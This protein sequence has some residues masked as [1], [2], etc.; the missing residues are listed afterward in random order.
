MLPQ[1]PKQIHNLKTEGGISFHAIILSMLYPLGTVMERERQFIYLMTR[2]LSRVDFAKQCIFTLL[3][4]L[5][6]SNQV[7]REALLQFVVSDLANT[8]IQ[9]WMS[10]F[11]T[12]DLCS[13][14]QKNGQSSQ[15]TSWSYEVLWSSTVN[16]QPYQKDWL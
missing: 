3:E 1:K 13:Q 2:K 12:E 4:N 16:G 9:S 6:F 5:K 10:T 11:T 7:A 15:I 8:H 14:L